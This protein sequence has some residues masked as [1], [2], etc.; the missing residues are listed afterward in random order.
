MRK[1]NIIVFIIGILI[2]ISITIFMIELLIPLFSILGA[3]FLFN[4]L[5]KNTPNI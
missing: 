4:E 5:I 3:V 2:G 1:S